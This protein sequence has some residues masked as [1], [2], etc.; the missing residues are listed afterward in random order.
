MADHFTIPKEVA[1]RIS[2]YHDGADEESAAWAAAVLHI[3]WQP[4]CGCQPAEAFRR[5]L[6]NPK[7]L[8]SKSRRPCHVRP[9]E[10][11]P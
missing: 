9:G 2:L 6:Q 4:C 7:A 5:E 3:Q 11:R 1:D 10:S 8:S